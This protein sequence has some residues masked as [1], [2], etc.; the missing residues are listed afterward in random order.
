V[1]ADNASPN[2]VMIAELSRIIDGFLGK[3]M[4]VRCFDHSL[5]LMAK[6][7]FAHV[8]RHDLF[9]SHPS[10]TFVGNTIRVLSGEGPKTEGYE[11]EDKK[12]KGCGARNC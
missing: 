10:F 11:E 3:A 4:H 7:P 12:G 9:G 2:D 8:L 6:V 5:N 1:A